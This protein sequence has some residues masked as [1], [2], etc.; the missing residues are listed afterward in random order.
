MGGNERKAK[1]KTELSRKELESNLEELNEQLLVQGDATTAQSEI[2]KKKDAEIARLRKEVEEATAAGEDA[3]T[4]LKH[5][6]VAALQEA[7]DETE[8]VKKAKQK[9]DKDKAA[10]ASELADATADISA[11]KKSKQGAE[12]TIRTLEDQIIDLKGRMEEQDAALADSEA[13]VSKA[14]ADGGNTGKAL[15]EAEHKVG[16][17]TK[18]KKALEQALEEA[19]GEAESESKGKHDTNLKLKAAQ[20][21][22]EALSE[23]LEEESSS[24]AALQQK[25]SKALS[26]P[27]G[28]GS[29][30]DSER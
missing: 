11:L 26:E 20:S 25:L 1:Q 10:V 16:L 21:E 28:G 4:A 14:V 2:A 6:H 7:Q 19:R 24:K 30:E 8:V 22:I 17:L 13:K 23:Q 29:I 5:K 18:D 27:R 12:K 3:V 9:S 15:E